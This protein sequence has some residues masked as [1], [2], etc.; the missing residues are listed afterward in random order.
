MLR[1]P[2]DDLF[3]VNK[4]PG[5]VFYRDFLTRAS[6]PPPT[7]HATHVRVRSS[8]FVTVGRYPLRAGA[9]RPAVPAPS[10]TASSARK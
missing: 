1:F 6:T 9:Q 4:H 3:A 8:V 10:G 5:P 7:K 2:R